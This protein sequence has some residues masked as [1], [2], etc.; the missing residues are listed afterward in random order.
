MEHRR[1][2]LQLPDTERHALGLNDIYVELE[3]QPPVDA[4]PET[5]TEKLRSREHTQTVT[6][7]A[8]IARQ[9]ALVV[10]GEPGGGKST[11]AKHLALQLADV[12]LGETC[13]LQ[14]YSWPYCPPRTCPSLL[15]CVRL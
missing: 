15:N 6:S 13:A 14:E 5:D 9:Q 7:V 2:K 8:A 4:D 11:V 10:L 12:L 1:L 3:A